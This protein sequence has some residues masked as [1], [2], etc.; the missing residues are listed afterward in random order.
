[1][2]AILNKAVF[3]LRPRRKSIRSSKKQTLGAL[4]L[5]AGANVVIV[6]CQR[7]LLSVFVATKKRWSTTNTDCFYN[8]SQNIL[9]LA[10]ILFKTSKFM[11]LVDDIS[12]LPPPL[13]AML[14]V[15]GPTIQQSSNFITTN[16]AM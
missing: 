5:L 13:Q 12:P 16:I 11:A 1:M 10:F 6:L 7:R 14:V 4:K 3:C 9:R 8:P 15:R 2:K